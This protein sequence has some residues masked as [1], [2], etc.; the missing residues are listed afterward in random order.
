MEVDELNQLGITQELIEV[1]KNRGFRELTDIQER[2][3]FHPNILQ[4]KNL[5]V[6]APTTS[7]KTFV[8]EVLAVLAASQLKRVLYLVPYKAMADEKYYEFRE[9]YSPLRI[10]VVISSGDHSEFDTDLRT[11]GFSI[12]I[13]I[14][15]KL[16]QLAVQSPGIIADCGL[17]VI[18]EIQ[19]IRDRMRGPILEM[20]LTRI[21]QFPQQPQIVGLSATVRELN[22]LDKWLNA[23]T[24]FSSSR[25]VPLWE[26]VCDLS[27]SVSSFNV[28]TGE[29][30]NYRL[31]VQSPDTEELLARLVTHFAEQGKQILVFR[32]TPDATEKTAEALALRLPISAVHGLLGQELELLEES[33]VKSFLQK[34]LG[35]K[36]S[37][38]NASLST[39]ERLLIERMF[40]EEQIQVL[41]STTTLALGVNL[42]ADVVIMADYK[43][44]DDKLR[45]HVNI[46]VSEYKNSVGRA[47]RKGLVEEGYSFLLASDLLQ[48]KGFHSEYIQGDLERMDSAIPLEPDA[49]RHVLS[50]VASG[51]AQSTKDVHEIFKGSYAAQT[52]YTQ[53]SSL[54]DLEADIKN[55]LGKCIEGGLIEPDLEEGSLKATE[56]GRVTA[57]QGVSVSSMSK[58]IA[59]L[60]RPAPE[61][62]SPLEILFELCFCDEVADR[63]PYLWPDEKR[64]L[65]WQTA[66]STVQQVFGQSFLREVISS[67][68]SPPDDENKALKKCLLLFNWSS[69]VRLRELIDTFRVGHGQIRDR[70]ETVGWLLGTTSETAKVLGYD[71]DFIDRL[72]TL[73]SEVS[74]GVPK[75]VVPIRQ[76]RVPGL[77]RDKVIRLVRNDKGVMFDSLDKIVDAEMDDFRGILDPNIIHPLQEAILRDRK[78]SLQRKQ[79]GHLI[80]VERLA[81]PL[82][83]I[84]ELY[85]SQGTK[86]EIAVE[87][88]LNCDQ[89]SFNCSRV[90]RQRKGEADIH[91]PHIDGTIVIQ[92]TSSLD[93]VKPVSWDKARE[94]LA[95]VGVSNPVN[96][97]TV[98]KPDFHE[99]AISNAEGLAAEGSRRLLLVP[100]AVLAEACIRVFEGKLDRNV[101]LDILGNQTGYLRSDEIP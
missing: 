55:A 60:N 96:F 93:N 21:R 43:R 97:I 90:P 24:I 9:V 101:L 51:L 44:W 52:F 46:P 86:F 1:W 17:L 49:A 83:M 7:G 22:G 42:P 41:V 15:E 89:I 39:E 30:R 29:Q 26:S 35:C 87:R 20:L 33:N 65:K 56:L 69:G 31:D 59:M 48:A 63:P 88:L 67:R 99:L 98:G 2:A 68:Q 100:V 6:V 36:V 18:D 10:S 58:I 76:L 94:V 80:R 72:H 37:Y 91:L 27:G 77:T 79:K 73:A 81:L 13:V 53:I 85:D 47:G 75:E 62:Y 16:S 95:S 23:D 3:L 38:H 64:T 54:S 14:S 8:G 66:I 57:Q 12:A 82:V 78:E 11:G 45:T 34:K 28:S 70:G 25:P 92:V 19:M 71:D 32:S 84:R 50:M 40:R 74:F 61:S 4:R 5:L